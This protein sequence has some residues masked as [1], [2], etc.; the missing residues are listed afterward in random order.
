MLSIAAQYLIILC[1]KKV[2][3]NDCNEI[4]NVLPRT[5]SNGLEIG[6]LYWQCCW[7]H[8][9]DY[10]CCILHGDWD[11]QSL[12]VEDVFHNIQREIYQKY[13]YSRDSWNLNHFHWQR[14]LGLD[15]FS[16]LIVLW[17][18][19]NDVYRKNLT[20]SIQ[21][22]HCIMSVCAWLSIECSHKQN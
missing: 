14:L 19:L 5:G 9:N 1:K 12:H 13:Y 2:C 8:W 18:C 3:S 17:H 21:T 10:Y 11:R 4:T 16:F 20:D 15:L 6:W 7:K 22:W